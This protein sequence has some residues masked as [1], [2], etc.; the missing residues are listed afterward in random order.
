MPLLLEHGY[1]ANGWLG[2]LLGVRLWFGFYGPV[3]EDNAAFET[4]MEELC[5]ELGDKGKL[6][7][8]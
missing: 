8:A 2:M 7:T 6:R 4:K 1:R 3:L 5:R